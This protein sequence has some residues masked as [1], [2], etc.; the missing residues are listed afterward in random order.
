MNLKA[1]RTT[2]LVSTLIAAAIATAT[3]ALAAGNAVATVNGTAIPQ[4]LANLLVAERVSQGAKD[5]PE[6]RNAVREELIQRELI[7]QDAKKAGIDKQGDLQAAMKFAEQNVMI[8]AYMASFAQKHPVSDAQLKQ[9]YNQINAGLGKEEF[10]T[11]HI[12][13]PSEAQAK[14]MITKLDS[15]DSFENLAKQNSTDPGSKENGGD[16]GWSAPSN[17]VKPFGD[18]MTKLGKGKY[19][20]EPVKSDFGW[21][22]ILVEDRRPLTPPPFEQV[23][24]QLTQAI[25][26]QEFQQQIAKQRQ[27]AKIQ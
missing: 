7:I 1:L 26:E 18:A 17:F 27:G 3:P 13:V 25:Q 9:A 20:K 6:L 12:L 4:S 24:G 16:L 8:R 14:D 15:G 22:V 5:T 11:R 19:T 21:H 10:K 2:T 23:K